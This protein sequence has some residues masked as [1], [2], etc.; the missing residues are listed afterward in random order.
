M[1]YIKY[2]RSMVGSKAINLT[3]VNVIIHNDQNEIL[4]QKRGEYPV[5]KWSLIGGIVELG[6]SLADAAKREAFEET[7]L[8]VSNLNLLGT[9]SGKNAYM[10]LPNGDK[11]YF[12]SIAFYTNT[13][14]GDIVI[15]NK[16]TLDLKFFGKSNLPDNMPG[17]HKEM[18][19][20]FYSEVANKS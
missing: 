10:E 5:G 8:H 16:E 1:D 15:D 11:A 14:K 13:Y 20:Q 18:I 17:T 4:L 12:I 7:S 6:E 9:T 19:D 3:G 2:I